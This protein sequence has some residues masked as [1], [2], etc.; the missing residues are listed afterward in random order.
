[1]LFIVFNIFYNVEV[2]K[3][4]T[5]SFVSALAL[6]VI[7]KMIGHK[8]MSQLDLFDYITGITIGSIAA[9]LATNLDKP[10]WK[11]LT[12]MIVYGII[13]IL[14]STVTAKYPKTRKYVNGTPT[15]IMDNG[16][17]YRDN[18]KKAKLELSE[19]LMMCR[20]EGYFDLSD[21][22][23]AVFECNG[24]LTILPVSTKRPVNPEDMCITPEKACIKTEV[25][26]DG[27]IL[28]EN[29]KRMG[30][31]QKWLK[32]Q[33]KNQGDDLDEIMLGVC[34]ENKKLTL[35]GL[36]PKNL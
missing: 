16:K 17:I 19:F 36:Y 21:I 22:Q 24:K 10:W 25:I 35:F 11:P 23:T 29:L 28:D 33:L 1:M 32:E 7:A 27:R 26:M 31:D 5:L 6:F 14:L 12:S 15:I 30:L 34:G 2:I 3:V 13:T 8:Q 4:I 18:L 20:Q 9:E